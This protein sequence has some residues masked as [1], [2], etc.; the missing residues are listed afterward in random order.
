MNL[1]LC[2][3]LAGLS[4]P[5]FPIR[6]NTDRWLRSSPER[7]LVAYH[8]LSVSDP[9]VTG[10][11]WLIAAPV[12]RFCWMEWRVCK[13]SNGKDYY[14]GKNWNGTWPKVVFK[15]PRKNPVIVLEP[16]YPVGVAEKFW[17]Q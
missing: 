2:L 7:R 1:A 9:E 3:A 5:S 13:G 16:R 4:S 10:R 8:L 6:E 12:C 11:C 15:D 14:W 17:P